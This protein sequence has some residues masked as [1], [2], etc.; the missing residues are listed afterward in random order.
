MQ[1]NKPTSQITPKNSLQIRHWDSLQDRI[2][3][4]LFQQRIRQR[5]LHDRLTQGDVIPESGLLE[6]F[7]QFDDFERQFVGE[8]GAWFLGTSMFAPHSLEFEARVRLNDPLH[9]LDVAGVERRYHAVFDTHV[10]G[11]FGIV[12]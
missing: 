10:F 2:Q 7:V 12:E 5:F 3:A 6:F 1:I 9:V 11:E 4:K 8:D